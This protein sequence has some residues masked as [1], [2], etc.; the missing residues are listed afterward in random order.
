MFFLLQFLPYVLA[1]L[2][3]TLT[4]TDIWEKIQFREKNDEEKYCSIERASLFFERK[5]HGEN[6]ILLKFEFESSEYCILAEEISKEDVLNCL[7]EKL[8]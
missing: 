4:E 3:I 5:Y 6:K 1:V 7:N 8:R 2:Q